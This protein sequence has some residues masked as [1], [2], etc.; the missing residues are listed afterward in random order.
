MRL[1]LP[2]FL[3]LIQVYR[4][5]AQPIQINQ[6]IDSLSTQ[7]FIIEQNQEN[8]KSDIQSLKSEF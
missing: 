4:L 2:I 7:N 1:V 3:L 8:I 6:R 5:E